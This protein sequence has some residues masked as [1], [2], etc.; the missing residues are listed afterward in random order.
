MAALSVAFL[1]VPS[2]FATAKQDAQA[3][4]ARIEAALD[5]DELT[6]ATIAQQAGDETLLAALRQREAVGLRLAAVRCSPYLGDPD[7]ALPVLAEIASGRDPELAPGAALR[8]FQIAQQLVHT[9][10]PGEL[11]LEGVKSARLQALRLAD[12][13]SALPRVR[14]LAGEASFLLGQLVAQVEALSTSD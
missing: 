2:V 14:V 10:A 4:Q 13:G 7:R 5:A 1:A 11:A 3:R 12:D 6:R 8:L 9:P